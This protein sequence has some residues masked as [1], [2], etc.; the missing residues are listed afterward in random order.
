MRAA[1][2]VHTDPCQLDAGKVGALV[3]QE[4]VGGVMCAP[5]EAVIKPVATHA[6][7]VTDKAIEAN[8]G[9]S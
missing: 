4:G 9:H 1:I 8:E 2:N 5:A 3:T 7:R 6:H